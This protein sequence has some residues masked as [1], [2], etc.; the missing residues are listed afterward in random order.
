MSTTI[1]IEGEAAAIKELREALAEGNGKGELQIGKVETAT[2]GRGPMGMDPLTYF[3]IGVSAHLTASL[4]HD[5]LKAYLPAAKQAL[6]GK[7]KIKTDGT[8]KDQ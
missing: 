5:F 7:V 3:A 4:L 6:L 8:P 2:P 1:R